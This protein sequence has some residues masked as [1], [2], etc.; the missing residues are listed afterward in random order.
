M[1]SALKIVIKDIFY[2]VPSQ[3]KVVRLLDLLILNEVEK[4]ERDV[5]VC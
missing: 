4:T 1:G 2:E 5:R 3:G